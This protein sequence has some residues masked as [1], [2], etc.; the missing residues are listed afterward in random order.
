MNA[1]DLMTTDVVQVTPDTPIR[2]VARTLLSHQISAVPVID[3]SGSL[4]GMVSEGD[5]VGRKRT[6]RETKSEWWLMR[7][8]EGEPLNTQFLEH[9][10]SPMAVAREVMTSPVVAVS[11]ETRIDEIASLMAAHRIKRLPVLRDG[12]VVGIVRRADLLRTIGGGLSAPVPLP[13]EPRSTPIELVELGGATLE[14]DHPPAIPR[15]RPDEALSVAD[16]RHLV[17]DFEDE[18]VRNRARQRQDAADLRRKAV[19]HLVETHISDE[20]WKSL[21][22]GARIAAERGETEFLLLRFPCQLCS[23]GGRAINAPDPDWPTTLRGEAAEIYLRWERD[24]RPRGFHLT[25]RVVDFPDGIPGDIGLYLV[26]GGATL[27]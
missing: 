22:H 6:E 13:P 3:K 24:L 1:R 4:V 11:E 8:A 12:H 17:S 5:L 21:V 25:A 10:Q 27:A 15:E 19:R 9:L 20:S 26:W 2:Q 16:F 23:D 14:A 7:L 18:E